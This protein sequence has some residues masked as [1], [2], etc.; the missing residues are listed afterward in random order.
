MLK[1]KNFKKAIKTNNYNELF[2]R[3]R[4]TASFFICKLPGAPQAP[5]PFRRGSLRGFRVTQRG[6]A[7]SAALVQ[8]RPHSPFLFLQSIPGRAIALRKLHKEKA[9]QPHNTPAITTPTC[10]RSGLTKNP[11]PGSGK[12]CINTDNKACFLL[13]WLSPHFAVLTAILFT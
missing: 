11:L 9:V 1:S 13:N 3:T 10:N 7:N 12:P 2:Q 6:Q 4:I 5:P 8:K